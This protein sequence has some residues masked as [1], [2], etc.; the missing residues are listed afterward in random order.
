M[1]QRSFFLVLLIVVI[2][3]L[4]VAG[5]IFAW[6]LRSGPLSLATAGLLREPQAPLLVPK[7]SPLMFSLLVNP[8]SLESLTSSRVPIWQ[9]ARVQ[10]DIRQLEIN[11]LKST[12]LDYRKE[13]RPWIGQEIT[14]AVT[15]LDYDHNSVN[16][17]EPGYLL[18]VETKNPELSKEFLQAAYSK[19][20][21]KRNSQLK[22]ESYKGVNI[23]TQNLL[24]SKPD[25]F[26]TSSAVLADFVLFANRPKILR[27]AINTLQVNNLSLKK[28]P[29][30]SRA[31]ESVEPS[32]LGLVY[33]NLPLVSAWLGNVAAPADSK[34]VQTLTVN[35]TL[36]QGG[37]IAQTALINDNLSDSSEPI[38]SEPVGALE[39]VPSS[40][41]VSLSGSD[42]PALWDKIDKEL[43]DNSPLQQILNDAL[44]RLE[45]RLGQITITQ[46]VF[47]WVKGEF[48]LAVIDNSKSES[49]DWL[50][51]VERKPEVDS[52]IENL[53]KMALEQGLSLGSLSVLGHQATVWSEF[54]SDQDSSNL[55]TLVK[56]IHATVENYEIFASSI[57]TL[58]VA[59]RASTHSNL[60][61]LQSSLP[62]NN[63]GYFY[64]NWE[65]FLPLL[66]KKYPIT[67]VAQLPLEPL[68]EHLKSLMLSSMG[69]KDG[70]GRATV[71]F[72]LS[73]TK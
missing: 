38:L 35:L 20:A 61:L 40:S 23:I 19:N 15:S 3:M 37:L 11:L 59:I 25:K 24:N 29:L 49:P 36:D 70:V 66:A 1:K 14:L 18:A 71:Y 2:S 56:G 16:G 73:S 39:Y 50:F 41:I 64:L 63:D 8:D 69:R 31:L 32:R 57:E 6:T 68:L 42:L 52:G 34:I 60:A 44:R 9:R 53:N 58:K 30:Y 28:S 10:R 33:A 54:E 45:N 21:L 65:K 17:V 22:F 26:L 48:A 43:S 13:I 5:S 67:T 62:K 4:T 27:E 47:P 72:N 51:A 55:S 46:D 7:Q 12:G